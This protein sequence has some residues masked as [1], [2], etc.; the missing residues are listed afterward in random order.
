MPPESLKPEGAEP[1]DGEA[2]LAV[3]RVPKA[4]VVLGA[5][6]AALAVLVRARQGTPPASQLALGSKV[7]NA[8]LET[9]A[10][11]PVSLYDYAGPHGTLVIFIA[12]RCPV[13]NDYNQ[14]MA[15][16]AREYVARDF[17]V[18]GVNANRNEPPDEVARHAGEKGLGFTVLKDPENRVADYFGA[19]VTPEAYLF[20]SNWILRYHGRIDDSRNPA[21]ISTQ[22]LRDA[23]EA[24]AAGKPVAVAQTRA[25]GC[26]IKRVP[27]S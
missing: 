4:M 16:L 10:G 21:H 6:V 20:D 24:L 27:R 11:A 5:A 19:S 8:P 7:S 18:I 9:L 14:R 1:T 17:A 13:S 25:F 26:T 15:A 2:T 3:S 23:L 12:T 22:D